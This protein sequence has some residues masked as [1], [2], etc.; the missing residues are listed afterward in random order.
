MPTQTVNLGEQGLQDGDAIDP[1][2]NEH[3][4]SGNEVVIPAGTYDW[5]GGGLGGDYADATLRGDAAGGT[6]TLNRPSNPENTCNPSTTA[7]GGTVRFENFTFRNKA[8]EAQ[9]RW[10][11]QAEAGTTLEFVNVN[12]PDG[13]TDRS[14]SIGFFC[15][16]PH[17]GMLRFE[18]CYFAKWGNLALYVD[19]PGQPGGNDGPVEVID[20]DFHNNNA[21]AV[22]FGSTDSVMR[23]CRILNDGQAPSYYN[24]AISQRGFRIDTAGS[25]LRIEDVDIAHKNGYGSIPIY[26][27]TTDSMDGGGSE[28][29]SGTIQSVRIYNDGNAD[30]II[31][32]WDTTDYW[33]GSDIHLTGPNTEVHPEQFG[34]V[35]GADAENADDTLKPVWRPEDQSGNEYPYEVREASGQ[36]ITVGDG[37]SLENIIFDMSTG[38]TVTITAKGTNWTIRNIGFDGEDTSGVGNAVFGLA[39]SGGGSSTFE[40]IYM[41]DGAAEGNE[42][43]STGYGTTAVWVDPSHTGH[44]EASNLYISA[45]PDNGFYASEDYTGTI[46]VTD[47][48]GHDNYVATWRGQDGVTFWNC[49]AYNDSGYGYNGR[50][51]WLWRGEVTLNGCDFLEGSYAGDCIHAGR[52]DGSAM[53]LNIED[54]EHTGISE[55]GSVTVNDQG[56]N[57]S[58]P[59]LSVPTGVPTSAREAASGGGVSDEKTKLLITETAGGDLSYTFDTDAPVTKAP[60]SAGEWNDTITDNGDG[61]YTVDGFTGNYSDDGYHLEGNVTGWSSSGDKQ[62]SWGG[63]VVSVDELLGAS[64]G[65]GDD[66]GDGD[67]GG[68]GPGDG[69]FTDSPS[70]G[71]SDGGPPMAC[72][73]PDADEI[74][75][76]VRSVVRE[77]L[78]HKA[79][80]VEDMREIA[81]D[82]MAEVLENAELRFSVG[83]IEDGSGER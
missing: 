72:D 13:T 45:F 25:N 14:D 70:E 55:T 7:V 52:D 57:G 75:E 11:V 28:R 18:R 5:N 51:A 82:A 47:S 31:E 67:G 62:L 46:T 59:D 10:R 12:K 23:N 74:E 40:N 65:D 66:G 61:T 60:E 79:L 53:T 77:E 42:E 22:K 33:T 50:C 64:G 63:R 24:G 4:V 20:C 43:S 30:S 76:I 8:G 56:G 71:G 17:A 15:G 54:T 37:E 48:Y 2:L 38:E 35:T 58:D 78:S 6:I 3:F 19:A 49:V 41:G 44:I 16:P 68:R 21:C 73:A 69:D 27:D 29:H 36:T 1:Y 34:T 83:D 9:S 32:A 26:L 80:S 81:R 39:D